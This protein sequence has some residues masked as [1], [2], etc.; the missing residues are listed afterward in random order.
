MAQKNAQSVITE[1]HIPAG[2]HG[3]GFPPFQKDTFASQLLWLVLVFVALYL[4]M[5]RLALPRIGS[6]LEQRK[7]RVDGDLAQAA[8]LKSESDAAI[9]AYEAALADARNRAQALANETRVQAA[10]AAETARKAL[11]VKLNAR[12][13]AA[14]AAIAQTRTAAMTN[15]QTIATE[16]AAAIVE[17]LIGAT[18]PG[19]QVAN[20]VTDVLKR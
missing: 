5:S 6:I 20:A 19:Q 1:E 17:R 9:A 10:A 8:S 12:I 18:P 7:A 4:V 11:D 3:G 15:V 14:E 16:A 2:E 13:A